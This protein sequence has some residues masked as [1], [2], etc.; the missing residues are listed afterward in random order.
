[1]K[2]FVQAGSNFKEDEICEFK[3][4]SCYP[5]LAWNY[6]AHMFKRAG[7]KRLRVYF[8]FI[9]QFLSV[10]I[11]KNYYFTQRLSWWTQYTVYY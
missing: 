6:K 8:C 10:I 11:D 7:L 9:L 4:Y 2:A 5:Y 1:M 3:L